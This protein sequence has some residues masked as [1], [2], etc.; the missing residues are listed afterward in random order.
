MTS[1]YTQVYTLFTFVPFFVA[2]CFGSLLYASS[3]ACRVVKSAVTV[4]DTVMVQNLVMPFFCFLE[5]DVLWFFPLLEVLASSS[6][7]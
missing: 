5:K 4:I 1:T 7:F 3:V 2:W 6:K